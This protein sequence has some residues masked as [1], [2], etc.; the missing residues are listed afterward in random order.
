MRILIV[1]DDFVCREQLTV[2]LLAYGECVVAASGE[3]GLAKFE[4][5][6]QDARP[7]H[8]VTMDIDMPGLRGQEVVGRIRDFEQSQQSYKTGNESKILMITSMTN[9]NDFFS[10]FR[11]G[12]EW[13][14]PKPVTPEK[15]HEALAKLENYREEVTAR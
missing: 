14:L 5:A 12:C 6:Y 8:L 7:F 3:E 13:Y 2:L 4:G 1:D 15:L 11:A 10:S 9:P